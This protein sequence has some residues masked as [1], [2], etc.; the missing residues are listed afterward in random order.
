MD[1]TLVWV[2]LDSS[3]VAQ[4]EA[5]PL[6]EATEAEAPPDAGEAEPVA[7][8]PSNVEDIGGRRR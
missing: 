2:A 1:G 7:G 4:S 6:T 3:G 5:E 8:A